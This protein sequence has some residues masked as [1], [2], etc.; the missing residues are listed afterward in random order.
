MRIPIGRLAG[1]LI[2]LAAPAARAEAP[3]TIY[4]HSCGYCHG[5]NVGPIILGRHLPAEVIK[6]K[7][8]TGP[9]AMPAFRPTEIGDAELDALA[10][11][12]EASPPKEQ[13][14]GR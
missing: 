9:N 13:E 12:I 4:A 3:A 6:E 14:H 5:T 2:V 1:C 10:R 8:R 7:V 11:W